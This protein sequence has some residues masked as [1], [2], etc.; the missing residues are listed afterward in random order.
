MFVC[1]CERERVRGLVCP[2]CREVD[3]QASNGGH[4]ARALTTTDPDEISVRV[5]WLGA[6]CK[7]AATCL[8][9][10]CCGAVWRRRAPCDTCRAGPVCV[11]KN[12]RRTLNYLV[13]QYLSA[14]GYKL[15]AV[16]FAEEVAEEQVCVRA[17]LCVCVCGGGGGGGGRGGQTG[18]VAA[19]LCA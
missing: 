4:T 10:C 7:F 3:S 11:Q 9:S 6:A 19:S 2:L 14:A 8:K 13:K 5:G 16:T 12:E 17:C 15:S 1:V 18:G